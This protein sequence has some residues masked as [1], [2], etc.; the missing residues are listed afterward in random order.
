MLCVPPVRYK[1]DHASQTVIC[2]SK[3]GLLIRFPQKAL[4]GRLIL[5]QL[6]ADTYPLIPVDI[7]FFLILA[8]EIL[9]RFGRFLFS[10]LDDFTAVYAVKLSAFRR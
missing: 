8:N 6:S 5:L 4:F 7:I 3:P 9:F 10:V 1:G 2:K